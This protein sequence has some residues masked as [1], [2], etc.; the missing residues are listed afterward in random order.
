MP[1]EKKLDDDLLDLLEDD[2]L[3]EEEKNEENEEENKSKIE[4]KFDELLKDKSDYL[5]KVFKKEKPELAFKVLESMKLWENPPT[6]EEKS[7][8]RERLSQ[9]FWALYR[10][11]A[12]KVVKK[13]L[14]KEKHRMLRYG[15]LDP[16]YITEGQKKLIEKMDKE[17]NET[18]HDSIFLAD[19]WFKSIAKGDIRQSV[20]DETALKKKGPTKDKLDSKKGQLDAEIK[21]AKLKIEKILELESEMTELLNR[22]TEHNKHPEFDDDEIIDSYESNQR[23]ALTNLIESGRS[24]LR[25]DKQLDSNFRTIDKI[26]H[27]LNRLEEAYEGEE[28]DEEVQETIFNEF[29]SFRQMVKMCAGRQ[30]NHFPILF[31]NYLAE[32][33]SNIATKK[34][35]EKIISD[36]EKLDPLLFVRTYKG[37]EHRIYPYVLIV[38]GY[39][40]KGICWEPFARTNRATS[41][42]RIV[43]PMFPKNLKAAVLSALADI[44]WQVAKEKAQHYWMEEGLTGYY[45]EYYTNE[46]LKGNIKAHFINDYMLWIA[47]EAKGVQR[48]HK[49]VRPVF[50]RYT[51]FPQKIKE[52]LKN[53]GFYYRDLYKKDQNRSM[54]DGY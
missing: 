13:S 8:Y 35:I 15:L 54:S 20:L 19:E 42:G 3:Y 25:V 31:K 1:D 6:K 43:I 51:P 47:W 21:S 30:G 52:S 46:K 28:N 24:L 5:K 10:D 33:I 37:E 18:K 38:P 41:K 7:K 12:P 14:E 36:V 11:M 34:N 2:V 50:W 9:N 39:G 32:D 23:E 44:R 26:K 27:G 49:D 16:D 53:R 45:Y 29:L 48:L 22:I 40:T 4:K 17:N